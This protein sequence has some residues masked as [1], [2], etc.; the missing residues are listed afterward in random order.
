[1]SVTPTV[2]PLSNDVVRFDPL[3][4]LPPEYDAPHAQFEPRVGYT[5]LEE[6]VSRTPLDTE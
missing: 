2:A 1:M 4:E 6:A 5:N 3:K